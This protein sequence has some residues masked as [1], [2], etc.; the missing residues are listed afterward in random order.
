M[1]IWVLLLV[2]LVIFKISLRF[3]ADLLRRLFVCRSVLCQLLMGFGE[4]FSGE[5]DRILMDLLSSEYS[6]LFSICADGI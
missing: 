4:L 2:S 5:K 1:P 6:D 3:Q